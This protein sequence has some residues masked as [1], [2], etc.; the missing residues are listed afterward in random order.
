MDRLLEAA[1]AVV[2][3]FPY[4]TECCGATYGVT[5]NE[6]VGRLTGRLLDMAERLEAS[7]VAVACPLCQ[8]NLD[9]RQ[10][11]VNRRNKRNFDIPVLYITQLLGLAMGIDSHELGLDKLFVSP[12]RLLRSVVGQ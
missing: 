8:Q 2:P 4:K 6:I 1:G 3:D 9:L 10:A 12:D 7:A 5:R 11:Q